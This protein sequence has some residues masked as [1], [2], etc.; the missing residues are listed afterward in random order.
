MTRQAA[1]TVVVG[2]HGTITHLLSQPSWDKWDAAVVM[3]S[4]LMAADAHVVAPAVARHLP[5]GNDHLQEFTAR[6]LDLERSLSALY[7]RVHG[8]AR[9]AG[10]PLEVVQRQTLATAGQYLTVRDELADRLFDRLDADT[11]A[12]IASRWSAAV[13]NAP[14]RPHPWL[15]GRR[16]QGAIAFHSARLWDRTRDLL[17]S[18]PT[19][20]PSAT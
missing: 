18:R 11:G 13:T 1:S 12:T 4:R 7:D 2:A 15:M 6:R 5:E 20:S 19:G 10:L 14:T 9:V 8:D 17:D 3:L 16:K